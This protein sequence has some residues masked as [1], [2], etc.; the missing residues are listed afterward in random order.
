MPSAADVVTAHARLGPSSAHR[1]ARCPAS[2]R[3]SE[4]VPHRPAGPAAAAGTLLH[5]VFER[6][7]LGQSHL[8]EHE[9]EWLSELD[10]GEARARYGIAEFLLERRVD[11]GAVIGRTDFWGTADLIG[12]NAD[13]RLLL[14]GDLK[15][16][17]GAVEVEGNDQMLAYAL[18]SLALLNFVPQRIVLAVFQPPVLGDQPALWETDLETLLSFKRFIS[19]RA[20]LTDGDHPPQPSDDA[21]QWC[22]AK[23]I[24]PAWVAGES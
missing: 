12:A 13:R 4:Q 18:G 16:G 3:L 1:W 19:E 21:C 10:M 24:C 20:A 2:I 14:V 7:M 8:H 23:S 15:T 9:I 5:A 11:P 6:Q 17:R 22:A